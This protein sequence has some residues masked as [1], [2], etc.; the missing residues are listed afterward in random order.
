[1]TSPSYDELLRDVARRNLQ[2]NPLT[3][4]EIAV[5]IEEFKDLP[6]EALGDA[7]E[8]FVEALK[9]NAPVSLGAMVMVL[10]RKRCEAYIATDVRDMR[11]TIEAEERNEDEYTGA[12]A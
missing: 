1:M 6:G 10:L 7:P 4:P 3:G 11:D 2:A 12:H 9:P 8:L 5:V